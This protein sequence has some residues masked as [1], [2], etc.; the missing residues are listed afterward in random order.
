M[1]SRAANSGDLGPRF[2]LH[3]PAFKTLVPRNQ[4]RAGSLFIRTPER[5]LSAAVAEEHTHPGRRKPEVWRVS[6]FFRF[7]RV[8]YSLE[9]LEKSIRE[10]TNWRYEQK[11]A[12]ATP[13]C[14]FQTG[15]STGSAERALP[16]L[17]QAQENGISQTIQPATSSARSSRQFRDPTTLY[18]G[19]SGCVIRVGV[20][21]YDRAF[22]PV[23]LWVARRGHMSSPP[24][25]GENGPAGG[26]ETGRERLDTR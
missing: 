13:S 2:L 8:R 1:A 19:G 7:G 16:S 5:G 4:N 15:R 3:L 18:I 9:M 11:Y 20:S 14:G 12:L 26:K 23:R 21:S 24:K 10:H 6:A 25:C 22:N 17:L